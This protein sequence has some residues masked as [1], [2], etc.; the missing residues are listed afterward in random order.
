[1]F[2]GVAGSSGGRV[3]VVAEGRAEFLSA[4]LVSGNDFDVL[5]VPPAAGRR[6]GDLD[7]RAARGI[8]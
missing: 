1:M 4:G 6:C 5:G 3:N 7:P 8:G 2:A